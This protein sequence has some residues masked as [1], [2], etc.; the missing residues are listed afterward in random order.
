MPDSSQFIGLA[1]ASTLLIL[2]PGPSVV[3]VV[4][5]ALS[6]GR[7]MAFASVAGNSVGCYAAAALVAI[8]LG[9]LLQRSDVLLQSIKWAGAAYLVWLGVRAL[10]DAAPLSGAGDAPGPA[11]SAWRSVRTGI[12]VGVSNPKVFLIF[13]A[14][15]PQF[16]DA[17]AGHVPTQMLLL[18]LVPVGVGLLTDSVW[19]LAAGLARNWLSRSPRRSIAVGRVGGLSMIALGVSVALTGERK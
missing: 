11:V 3:F 1:L 18:A 10:R 15:L 5:R 14:V 9:P 8:G 4:G 6:Y 17:E 7:R 13:A 12:L 2:V 16:V 19:A